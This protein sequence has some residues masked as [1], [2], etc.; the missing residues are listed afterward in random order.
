MTNKKT[1]LALLATLFIATFFSSCI[2]VDGEWDWDYE[3]SS[4]STT[5]SV[6]YNSVSYVNYRLDTGKTL[7]SSRYYYDDISYKDYDD[8]STEPGARYN[9][10]TRREL[11]NKIQNYLSMDYNAASDAASFLINNKHSI[12]YALVGSEVRYI[13]R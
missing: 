3:S 7:N 6:I 11:I 13:V 4:S 5:Y 9:S 1:L 2:I 8:Y 10:Y 12:V